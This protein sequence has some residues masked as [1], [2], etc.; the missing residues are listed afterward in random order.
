MTRSRLVVQWKAASE[1]VGLALT[2]GTLNGSSHARQDWTIVRDRRNIADRRVPRLSD[3]L[4]ALTADGYPGGGDGQR[5]GG[6]STVEAAVGARERFVADWRT[7]LAIV[8]RVAKAAHLGASGEM[9]SPRATREHLEDLLGICDRYEIPRPEDKLRLTCTGG[10]GEPGAIE[11]GDPTC[12]NIA[13]TARKGMCSG[14]YLRSYRW[15][16]RQEVA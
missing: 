5:G 11:W 3:A 14:C 13:A 9:W 8:G 4:V 16:R 1:L 6:S 12:T 7:T 15:T 10:Q 2:R